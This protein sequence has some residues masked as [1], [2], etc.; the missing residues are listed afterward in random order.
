MAVLLQVAHNLTRRI[1]MFPEENKAVCI[2]M[3]QAYDESMCWIIGYHIWEVVEQPTDVLH[4]VTLS[5]SE[6]QYI[7][8]AAE[9][10]KGLT[11]SAPN[12][13][14]LKYCNTSL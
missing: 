2:P 13:L 12:G 10:R 8:A 14:R 11:T 5:L 3:F 9:R 6:H 4:Q 7:Y 1:E